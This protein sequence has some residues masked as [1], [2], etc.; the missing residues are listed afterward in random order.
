MKRDER[1]A[2]RREDVQRAALK[3]VA[4]EGLSALTIQRVAKEVDASVGGLYRYYP[5]KEAMIM[6]VA[7]AILRELDEAQARD[8]VAAR[9][10]LATSGASE[11]V[12]ELTELM[13]LVSVY[14]RLG[15]RNF[16]HHALL[17]AVH[18]DVSPVLPVEGAEELD[19][20]VEP[21][22]V[23]V[24]QQLKKLEAN[25]TFVVADGTMRAYVLWATMFGVNQFRTRDRFVPAMYASRKILAD[26]FANLVTGF[27]APREAA[28]RAA[29]LWEK[30]ETELSAV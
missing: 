8:L 3:I 2:A 24:V 21:L 16:E 12:V 10:L 26:M 27:G 22:L 9:S 30:V 29:E 4:A 23:R 28:A 1:R 15:T 7:A 17:N 18:A 6:A 5:S 14:T 11:Q 19:K 25:G 13:L 20:A